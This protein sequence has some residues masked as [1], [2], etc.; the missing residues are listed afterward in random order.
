MST[1]AEVLGDERAGRLDAVHDGH[2]HVH[3]HDVGPQ[4]ARQLDGLGAVGGLADDLEVVLDRED[5][6]EAGPHELLVVDEE[7]AQ[8]SRSGSGT[9]LLER[10]PHAH[11]VAAGQ[12]GTDL[13]L[14]VRPGRALAHA[15]EAQADAGGARR[16]RPSSST[17]TSA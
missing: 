4:R 9:V 15:E 13:D 17:S 16:G 1:S 10:H 3:E 8:A 12:A 6:P 5:H 11:A 7:H 2:L 14:A